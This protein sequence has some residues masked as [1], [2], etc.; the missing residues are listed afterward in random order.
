MAAIHGYMVKK[1]IKMTKQNIEE[2]DTPTTVFNSYE[3]LVDY[4]A[5]EEIDYN[6]PNGATAHAS[7]LIS[8]LF[9]HAKNNVDIFCGELSTDVYNGED[10]IKNAIDFVIRR[11]GSIRILL[12]KNLGSDLL[13]RPIIYRIASE[14][15]KAK[16]KDEDVG[17][18]EVSIRKEDKPHFCVADSSAYRLEKDKEKKT[19]IANFGN[20]G[21]AHELA[22]DFKDMFGK[23]NKA[24][25]V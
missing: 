19:A 22:E 23:S 20:K 8:A 5:R 10:L 24:F 11:N 3:E 2:P 16:K 18:L 6:V 7:T 17:S 1:G 4:L 12:E 25:A 15:Y 13:E 21:I 9:K 14:I